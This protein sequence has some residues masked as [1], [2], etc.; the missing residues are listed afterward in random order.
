MK[1]WVSTEIQTSG[2]KELLV[3][4]GAWVLLIQMV[5]I[6][7]HK[8]VVYLR[9]SYHSQGLYFHTASMCSHLKYCIFCY[10]ANVQQV[11]SIIVKDRIFT[12]K[13]LGNKILLINS[14]N[15]GNNGGS[16]EQEEFDW[17]TVFSKSDWIVL[18]LVP[19]TI[20]EKKWKIEK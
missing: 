1:S 3:L 5:C 18:K 9:I 2:Q 15:S 20:S 16:S 12:W 13:E 7:S 10:N 14:G 4:Q 6:L 17:L 8:Q 19:R 11:H